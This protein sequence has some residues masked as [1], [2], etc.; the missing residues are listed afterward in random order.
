MK[1]GGR[2]LVTNAAMTEHCTGK[3]RGCGKRFAHI[4]FFFLEAACGKAVRAGRHE[5]REDGPNAPPPSNTRNL[6]QSLTGWIKTPALRLFLLHVVV[7]FGFL[8][9]VL[10]HTQQYVWR[11]G[12]KHVEMRLIAS[13]DLRIL[14]AANRNQLLN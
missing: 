14:R 12:Y 11:L 9:S 8:N 3:R 7:F 10:T 2:R 1:Q 4:L 5:A 13:T 6:A